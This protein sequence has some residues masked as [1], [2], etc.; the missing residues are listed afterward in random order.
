MNSVCT[1]KTPSPY[2]V[3]FE[4][5]KIGPK[6]APNRFYQV[7]H[8]SGMGYRHPHSLAA[9]REVKA[10]GGWG[11]VCSEY[12]SIHR[13][14]D[15]TPHPF[16]TL[17]NEEDIRAN[18]LVTE[19][20]HKHGALSA[21]ELCIAGN[22][23]GNLLSRT[24]AYGVAS[25]PVWEFPWQTRR[26]DKRD[27]VNIRRWHKEAARRAVTAGH[28]IVY[29]YATHN[30]FLSQFLWSD[31]NTRNDEYGG[32]LENRVRLVREIIED[33]LDA[34]AG[35]CAVAVRF[36]VDQGLSEAGTSADDETREMLS[37]LADLPDLWDLNVYDWYREIGPSRFFQ[38]GML[39]NFVHYARSVVTQ[40][41]VSTGRFTSPDTMARQIKSGQLDFIGAA[42]PS[43]ADPFLP[44]KIRD[45]QA[46]DI[47]EC[48]GCN[49]C[50]T[51]TYLSH[52]IRCTQNPAMGL[53]WQ[54]GWHPEHVPQAE[55]DSSVLVVGAGPAGLEAAL[56]AAKRGFTVAL[57]EA[58]TRLGGRVL[59]ES[60]LP[61]LNE[62]R[63][64]ADHRV[65]QLQKQVGADIYLDSRL[66]AIHILDYGFN[67]V[68]LATGARWRD[69]GVGRS[70]ATTNYSDDSSLLFSVNS[71][72]AGQIPSPQASE[73]PVIIYDDDGYYMA[74][75]IALRIRRAGFNTILVCSQA[76]AAH[77]SQYTEE[78]TLVNAQLLNEGVKIISSHVVYDLRD[79]AAVLRCLFSD[80]E[81]VLPCSALIPVTARTPTDSVYYDLRKEERNWQAAGIHSVTR[82]GDA[83][84]PGIIAQAVHAGR[85]AAMELETMAN[86]EDAREYQLPT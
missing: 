44:K 85:A 22:A 49:I 84:A 52:P 68:L 66:D 46:E 4:P 59:Q 75:V 20:I 76:T 9:M 28:D 62:W 43:I 27:I 72:L 30:Y 3:L 70:L 38:E 83:L 17:W 82:I 64:V 67:H 29:V 56:T 80:K 13:S 73:E 23:T 51:G 35:R 33:T 81:T 16:A 8:G 55:S 50:Y 12:T 24:P 47:R 21:V 25:V 79:D 69:D 54:R 45:G 48:I 18:A 86:S 19:A 37:I 7:P 39:E 2:E 65:Q 53:E 34:V 1:D 77:W 6:T 74:A 32:S 63:R 61:G 71:V 40:P 58:S 5:V 78:L 60:A 14:M 41:I 31:H 10:E 15:D 36:A 57:A 42:R 26:A 11:V